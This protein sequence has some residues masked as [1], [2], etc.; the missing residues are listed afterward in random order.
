MLTD[1]PRTTLKMLGVLTPRRCP[2]PRPVCSLGSPVT[3]DLFALSRIQ[4]KWNHAAV[5]P[6]FTQLPSLSIRILRS[7]RVECIRHLLFFFL[8]LNFILWCALTPAYPVVGS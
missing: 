5:D 4:Q 1:H 8:L 7:V 3:V 6:F 2:S